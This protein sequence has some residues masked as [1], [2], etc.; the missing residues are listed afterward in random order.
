MR[1]RGAAPRVRR[2]VVA[3]G[4]M[5]LALAGLAAPM[6]VAGHAELAEAD[7]AP[8]A[9]V[10][11]AP[12]ALRLRFTEAVDPATVAIVLVDARQQPVA[13]VGVPTVDGVG[14]GVEASVPALEPGVY[15]VSYQVVSAVDGHATAGSYAFLVDPSGSQAP[16]TGSPES[17]ATAVDAPTIA[18]RWASLAAALLALGTV[19]FWLRAG[20]RL[21]PPVAGSAPQAAPPWLV[22][23]IASLATALALSLYL[24]LSARP[25][26]AAAAAG[27]PGHGTTSFMLDFAAPF[28]WTPFAI[29]MRLALAASFLAFCLAIGRHFR[30]AELMRRG[31]LA[32]VRADTV[33]GLALLVLIGTALLG[34]SLAG[35]ASA[36]AGPIG[37]AIDWMHLVAAGLWLGA[38]PAF[39]VAARRARAAGTRVRETLTAAMREHGPV[40]LVAAPVV[41]LTGI[42]NSRAVTG[43]QRDLVDS[44]YGNL[45][46]AKAGL[47][48]IALGI[49]AVNHFVARGAGRG[50]LVALIGAETVVAALAVM[51]AATMVTIQPAVSR[52][53]VTSGTAATVAHL[54]G[55]AGPSTVHVIV[56]QPQPGN[57][58]YEVGVADRTSGMPRD[59]VQRVFLNF[60]PPEGSDLS[61]QRVA[62]A[63]RTE[64]QYAATGNYTP[65]VGAWQLE[66]VVRRQGSVDET[67]SFALPVT[68]PIPP[69]VLP[70]PDTGIGVPA[71]LGLAWSVLPSGAAAWIPSLVLLT[72]AAALAGWRRR[73]APRAMAWIASGAVLA[74]VTLGVAAGSRAVVT[75]AN[76]PPA[77]ARS[78][79][80]PVPADAASVE[81]G[82]RL[83]LANCA[84]C[85]GT[86]GTGGGPLVAGG[87]RPRPLGEVIAERSDGELAY[88]IEYGMVGTSMPSFAA[89]LTPEDRWDLVNYLRDRW[90]G[91]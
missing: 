65:V 7:P 34:V 5:L 83:F 66:A 6:P 68:E 86:D 12:P 61:S 17:T 87:V 50:R 72:V 4:A 24:A 8:N 10:P 75:A 41:A 53:P 59:D 55:E 33:I 73:G 28:G 79:A 32:S 39:A 27:H 45:L 51:A 82:R 25:I 36:Y 35:H 88:R 91:S 48:A 40:A 54:Y 64:G 31:T 46:L 81:R 90:P 47:F 70:P 26:L 80:N 37:T 43:G 76:D 9:S 69:R 58:R 2:P 42:A 57:Q 52:Q 71:P 67:A 1:A 84:A 60:V 30:A 18:A 29:A 13:G 78:A 16:P 15:T 62:L 38:L 23:A 20:R 56:D 3:A 44:G 11:E 19:A 63:M 77:E 22:V 21:F 85:H 89:S 74:A 14:T 49:G